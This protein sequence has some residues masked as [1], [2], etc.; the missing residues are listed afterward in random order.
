VLPP[1][2][3][4]ITWLRSDLVEVRRD[5]VL[6]EQELALA[7]VAYRPAVAEYFETLSRAETTNR[8]KAKP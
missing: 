3:E 4:M 7:P 2:D 6:T 5:H 8:T 1:L